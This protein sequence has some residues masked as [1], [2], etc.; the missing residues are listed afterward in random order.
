MAVPETRVDV[1]LHVIYIGR[2]DSY[3]RLDLLLESRAQ[4][5]TPWKLV[6]VGDGP[7]RTY[8]EQLAK[9]LFAD[10]SLVRFVGCLSE[11]EKFE[12]LAEAD[13]L[14]LPSD[15]SNEAFGIVQLEAMA[16]CRLALAFDQRSGMSWVSHPRAA[17]V[18]VAGGLGGGAATVGGSTGLAPAAR[19]AGTRPLSHPVCPWGVAAA[20]ATVG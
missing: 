15:R 10:Q 5:S 6:V 2:L 3:K 20:V 13:L 16:A 7:K 9:N 17:L 11:T 1:S 12:C 19:P 4:L 18:A 8:F 14:V